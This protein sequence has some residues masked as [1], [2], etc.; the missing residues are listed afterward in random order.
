ME[1]GDGHCPAHDRRLPEETRRVPQDHARHPKRAQQVVAVRRL[2]QQE[3]GNGGGRSL[4]TGQ[5]QSG[6]QGTDCI[7]S[8]E[9]KSNIPALAMLFS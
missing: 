3:D 5:L 6:K 9:L 2:D 1:A 4:H 8:T 7:Q